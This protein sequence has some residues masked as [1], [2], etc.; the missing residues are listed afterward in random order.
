MGAGLSRT[1]QRCR[2][3]AL[4]DSL[5]EPPFRSQE[6][7]PGNS[8]AGGQWRGEELW[9]PAKGGDPPRCGSRVGCPLKVEDLSPV[10]KR[11]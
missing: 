2:Q 4:R 8:K 1:G 6:Y 10:C 3:K 7:P 11:S 5:W 9:A